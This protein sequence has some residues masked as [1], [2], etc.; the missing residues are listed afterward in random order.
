MA[1]GLKL[2]L[3]LSLI[4]RVSPA[5]VTQAKLEELKLRHPAVGCAYRLGMY[6]DTISSLPRGFDALP[7]C[8]GYSSYFEET[9]GEDGLSDL[10][11]AKI[12]GDSAS[13]VDMQVAE[14]V[15]L[16]REKKTHRTCHATYRPSS[17]IKYQHSNLETKMS[18]TY[19]KNS[20]VYTAASSGYGTALLSPQSSSQPEYGTWGGKEEYFNSQNSQNSS[21]RSVKNSVINKHHTT[22]STK[23]PSKTSYR[24]KPLPPTP[25]E[26]SQS[27][28]RTV[29]EE[30]P[31]FSNQKLF[32]IRRNKPANFGP[33]QM[34]QISGSVHTLGSQASVISGD[35]SR[36]WDL[37][38]SNIK[39]SS[40]H[41][42]SKVHSSSRSPS[43]KPQSG[44]ITRSSSNAPSHLARPATTRKDKKEFGKHAEYE[45]EH[46]YESITDMDNDYDEIP[47]ADVLPS[48]SVRGLNQKVYNLSLEH[49]M[50]AVSQSTSAVPLSAVSSAGRIAKKQ[51]Q[52]QQQKS[53]KKSPKSAATITPATI[54]RLNNNLS[55]P[56]GSLHK[57]KGQG[58]RRAT[59]PE[60]TFVKCSDK[61]RSGSQPVIN[62]GI[63]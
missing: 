46:I 26:L 33:V 37:K 25:F 60:G 1:V 4:R 50:S 3:V 23:S 8:D 22:D 17:F 51:Q 12:P 49:S 43:Q 14:Q 29:V 47:E 16:T 13:V 55:D 58:K 34:H 54:T 35:Y 21:D 42:S 24:T 57:R 31:P 11:F 45:A 61:P 30:K 41:K 53:L 48:P 52:L 20:G 59:I 32:D 2:V 19:V 15:L 36:P 27:P 62:Y 6:F 56:F 38:K 63:V 9:D 7:D 39:F 28:S 5:Q 18:T 40:G 10:M 44:P